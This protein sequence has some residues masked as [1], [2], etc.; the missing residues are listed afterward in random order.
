MEVKQ[1]ANELCA[2][3]EII[4]PTFILQTTNHAKSHVVNV[5]CR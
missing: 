3:Y 4:K 1:K 5:I 2:V